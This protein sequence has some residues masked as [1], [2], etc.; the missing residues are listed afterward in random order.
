MPTPSASG[1]NRLPLLLAM[2]YL[3]V[4]YALFWFGPYVWPVRAVWVPTLYVPA[5]F[6]LL[7]MGFIIGSRAKPKVADFEFAPIFYAAGVT[8]AMLLLIPTTYVYTAKLPWQA[9][10]ALADQK[11]AYSALAEQLYATQGSRGPIAFLRAAAGPFTFCVLPLGV[12]LWPRL[13]WLRRL[14]LIITILISIDLSILR[15]TTRELA[16]ILVIGSSAYLVRMGVASKSM[17]YNLFQAIV[18][19]WKVIILGIV[20]ISF[21][22][23]PLVGRTQIRANGRLITCIGYS[24]ICADLNSGIYGRM[25]DTFAFGSAAVTGYLSQG[26][27]GLSLAAEKPFQS[28]FGIGHS[29]PL[30][31]LFVSLGGDETWANRTYTYRNRIDA[32][33]DE[34][35]WSTMWAWMANDVGF[36]GALVITFLLGIIWGLTWIDAMAGDIRAAVLFCLV[37]MMIF[38][39][40]ANLQLTSTFEAYGTLLFWLGVWLLGRTRRFGAIQN[41]GATEEIPA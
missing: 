2:P 27:Y 17:G 11:Q 41:R 12:M 30:S 36:S 22:V 1:L 5:C 32:W 8:L 21:V 40:P 9:G 25:N 29:P 28:T 37:M 24:H 19:R 7:V 3:S 35:Q 13:S 6:A 31:A 38:Y 15:G 34:T 18:R 14:G 10:S 39:A 33:S 4:T 20:S 16:D 23:V 26:Y